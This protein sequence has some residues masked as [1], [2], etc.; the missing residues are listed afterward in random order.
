MDKNENQVDLGL[1][2]EIPLGQGRCFIVNN[3]EVALFRTR[4]GELY[5]LENRCPHKQGP[6]AEG[7]CDSNKVICPYHA[8]TFDLKTGKGGDPDE[9]VKTFKVMEKN[10]KIIVTLPSSEEQS[11]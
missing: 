6:L 7:V 5:A 1:V 3:E 11:E 10:K 8:H 9:M 4:S 2:S